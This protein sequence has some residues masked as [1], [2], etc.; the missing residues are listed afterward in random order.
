MTVPT[1]ELMVR[2]DDPVT[3]Q[4]SVLY[5]PAVIFAGVAVKL[6]MVGKLPTLTVTFAVAV[7]KLFLAVKV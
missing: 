5:W 6:A 2:V 3:T 4:A 7:P 1:P